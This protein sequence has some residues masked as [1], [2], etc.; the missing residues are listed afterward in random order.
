MTLTT[1]EEAEGK[2]AKA[3][4]D[5]VY[6]NQ[7][8][9]SLVGALPKLSRRLFMRKLDD[10]DLHVIQGR[11]YIRDILAILKAEYRR[12]KEEVKV[13][14]QEKPFRKATKAAT[15]HAV[16]CYD[17]SDEKEAANDSS[18]GD[19][20]PVQTMVS[21]QPQPQLSTQSKKKN[22]KGNNGQQ[23]VNITSQAPQYQT[24]RPATAGLPGAHAV[25]TTAGVSYGATPVYA[26]A[27]QAATAGSATASNAAAPATAAAAP[28]SAGTATAAVCTSQRVGGGGHPA[29]HYSVP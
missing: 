17:E 23:S 27:A 21:F 20:D 6:K 12:L 24:D 16:V 7:F 19:D 15:S 8:L 1:L 13:D 11:S 29:K 4:L 5:Y 2:P 3:V 10:E 18:S 14:A 22:K 26:T 28:T 9:K 25:H